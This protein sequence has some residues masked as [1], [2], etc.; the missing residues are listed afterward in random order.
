MNIDKIKVSNFRSIGKQVINLQPFNVLIGAN[1]SGKSNFVQIFKFL[2]DVDELGISE[3]I[4]IQ[5]DLD[6]LMNLGAKKQEL[7]IE[8][9][10]Y[11]RKEIFEFLRSLMS[12]YVSFYNVAIT[13]SLKISNNSMTWSN[14]QTITVRFEIISEKI[15][16]EKGSA[17]LT[18]LQDREGKI[19]V[20]F[21]FDESVPEE[22]V[23]QFE[24]L[25]PIFES[26]ATTGKDND[27]MLRVPFLS[28][29]V[30]NFNA[31]GIY[32]IDPKLAKESSQVNVR[33]ELEENGSNFTKSL[34]R[35]IDDKDK[36]KVFIN[37]LSDL[38]PQ[39]KN[40]NVEK[41]AD[42]TLI[43]KFSETYFDKYLP[44]FLMSDGAVYLSSLILALQFNNDKKI[45]IIEEPEKYI[46][47]ALIEKLVDYLMQYSK[48]KQI[49]ITSHSREIVRATDPEA[50]LTVKRDE[51]GN[52][53]IENVK[54]M[55]G[56][57]E[58]L[59]DE[60]GIDD[61]FSQGLLS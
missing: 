35:V 42:R 1:S 4:S 31:I 6:F 37:T 52:T 27:D 25:K 19:K 10:S 29:T 38:L 44:S 51:S 3:A 34:K 24:S 43:S 20:K 47:P 40:F 41:S 59:S 21:V 2:R 53:S 57:L 7:K 30:L 48:K 45:I 36:R 50:L 12:G 14:E 11:G 22:I 54:S 9:I 13:Y 23:K 5:G 60:V 33:N 39:L 56:I 18:L 55:K 61:L 32:D 28:D 15:R 58:F 16:E 26:R 46:H 49:I 17:E 8:V